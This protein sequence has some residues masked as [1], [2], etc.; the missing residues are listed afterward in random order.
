MQAAVDSSG[1]SVQC[2]ECSALFQVEAQIPV[3]PVVQARVVPAVAARQVHQTHPQ[4]PHRGRP[5]PAPAP[6][7]RPRK[8][9]DSKESTLLFLGLGGAC[10]LLVGLMV[11]INLAGRKLA[12]PPPPPAQGSG[13]LTTSIASPKPEPPPAPEDPE[14]VRMDAEL[15]KIK[16]ALA[17]REARDAETARQERQRERSKLQAEMDEALAYFTSNFF[18]GDEK[19]AE[20]FLEI[21][22]DVLWGVSN[23]MNDQDPANDLK[24]KEDFEEYVVQRLLVRFEKNEVLS[25]WMK[26]HQREPRKFILELTRT[27]PKRPGSGAPDNAFDFKKYAS[28]GSGFWISADGWILTNEHVV[29]DAKE[30]DLRLRDGKIIQAKVVKTDEANDLALLK[31][32]QSPASWQAVSKG[33]S[34]LPLGRT[35]FTVGYPDP[36]VQGVEPKFTDGRISAASGIEDRKDSYQTTVPVQHGNSGGALVDF[37]T[38][39]VV[40]VINAKLMGSNGASADNVSYAIKGNVVSA[41]FESVPEAKAAAV[42]APPKPVAKGNERDVIDRATASSV[43]ILRPR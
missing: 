25:R 2:P 34:D 7:P 38:G 21:Q 43:L 1:G 9:G 14:K 42:K 37:A 19:A 28:C 24:G 39:W 23:L 16:D 17:A 12:E 31:A 27:Q 5:A 33:A 30:V 13:A 10:V 20:A 8:S 18:G 4:P 29:S 3:V 40:G 6:P 11:W 36:I 41:F 15:K 26:L 32:T 35:V 22:N